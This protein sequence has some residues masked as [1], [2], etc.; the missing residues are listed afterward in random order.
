MI[1]NRLTAVV[2]AVRDDGVAVVPAAL[3]EVQLV[4]AARAHLHVPEPA[5]RVEREPERIAVPERPDLFGDAAAPRERIVA[6]HAAVGGEP[7]DLAEILLQVLRRRELLPLARADVEKAV[8]PERDAMTVMA[9]AVD[10]RALPPDD[11]EPFERGRIGGLEHEPRAG[12]GRAG[13]AA[14]ALFRIAQVDEAVGGEVGMQHDV[15]ETALPRVFDG[16]DIG[17]VRGCTD[18]EVVQL[19]RAAFLRHEQTAVG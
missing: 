6:R 5:V 17:D 18:V 2:I 14:L 9:A 3:H 13:R 15:A 11:G 7:H 12:D 4:A 10:L 8:G 16:R 19:Q 1:G